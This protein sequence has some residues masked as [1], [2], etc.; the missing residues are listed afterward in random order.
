[1]NSLKFALS[2]QDS[3]SKQKESKRDAN[4]SLLKGVNKSK[5]EALWALDMDS[6]DRVTE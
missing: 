2:T 5:S 6:N 1:M 3:E 4:G